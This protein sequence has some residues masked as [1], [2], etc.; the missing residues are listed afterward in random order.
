MPF[1]FMFSKEEKQNLSM[2]CL[3]LVQYV[4]HKFLTCICV[5][6]SLTS[7]RYAPCISYITKLIKA[8]VE[9]LRGH[10]Y[11]QDTTK[12]VPWAFF[13]E[14]IHPLREMSSRGSYITHKNLTLIIF[15]TFKES[16]PTRNLLQYT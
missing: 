3:S 6:A 13:Q 11:I 5:L 14:H 2:I 1:K 12:N 4:L 15:F 9:S 7:I 10:N 16:L 8:I